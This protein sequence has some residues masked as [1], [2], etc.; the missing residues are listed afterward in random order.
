MSC[1]LD[2][3]GLDP[4]YKRMLNNEMKILAH[5]KRTKGNKVIP[6]LQ[7]AEN[8]DRELYTKARAQLTAAMS[9]IIELIVHS[10]TQCCKISH[11]ARGHGNRKSYTESRRIKQICKEC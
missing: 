10:H 4:N 3:L 9:M 7:Q 5:Y 6:I 8:E 2:C 1:F 11:L